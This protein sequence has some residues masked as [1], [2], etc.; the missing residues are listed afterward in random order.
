MILS[1]NPFSLVVTRLRLL[2]FIGVIVLSHVSTLCF[3]RNE[4]IPTL[5]CSNAN[6]IPETNAV[7][8]I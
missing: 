5:I 7:P 4:I 8:L 3:L 2:N 6:R 1:Q